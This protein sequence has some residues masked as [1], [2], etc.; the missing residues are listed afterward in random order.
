MSTQALTS[1]AIAVRAAQVAGPVRF[2][3]RVVRPP[4]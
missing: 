3:R 4:C 1:P 2:E